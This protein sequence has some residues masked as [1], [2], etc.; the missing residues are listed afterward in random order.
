MRKYLT[1]FSISLQEFFT[2][3]LNFIM[4]RVRQ[5]FVFLIPYFL[6]RSV[7]GGGGEIYGYDFSAVMTYLFGTTILRSLVMGSRTVDLGSMINSGYLSIPLMKPLSIFRFFFTRDMADK[8]FNL[9]FILVEIPLIIA[10]F[11]P[12]VFLQSSP[13]TIFLFITSLILAILM[14]FFINIIF[15]S[16][17]FWTRDIWAPRFLLMV[18]MEFATGAM[19]PLDML[20]PILTKF[21]YFTPF[22][23]LLFVPLKLY[24]GEIPNP[25]AFLL[26]QA[27]WLIA[28][29]LLA[30]AVWQKGLHSYEA[31]GR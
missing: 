26:A 31:E 7:L 17:A 11:H 9:S 25:L 27:T 28:I 30:R 19:F 13:I 18:I 14:Y 29:Y 2:Y 16:L 21:L 1:I 20:S 23:Y 6:W 5:I 15:G 22:P 8:L 24:L 10:I 3:R 4:W 12:P